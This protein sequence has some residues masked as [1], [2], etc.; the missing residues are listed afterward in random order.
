VDKLEAALWSPAVASAPALPRAGIKLVRFVYAVLRDAL[1]GDL[2]LRAM[3][4]VY[5]TILS[6]VPLIAISFSVLK[7]FGFHKQM[8]P[9][10]YELLAPLG[11]RGVQLTDQVMGF[12]DNIQGDVLAYGGLALLFFTTISMAQKVEA[13][14]NFV[15]RVERSRNIAQ[16][17]TQYL[18]IIML[19]PVVMVTA[20]SLIA[21]AEN[22]AVVRE[23]TDIQAIG[24]SV[25]LARNL[26]PYLLV[27]SGFTFV[28]LF[29][30]NTRVRLG[31][32]AVGGLTGGV[33]WATTGI[34]FAAF[35]A[36]SARTLNIYA[37]FAIVIIALIWLY[38]CWLI[39]LVGAQV[40]FYTQH[41]EHLRLGF[42][43]VSLGS[44]QRE[45]IALSIMSLAAQR[46]RDGQQHPRLR[47]VATE[48]GLPSLALSATVDRL[49][50]AGLLLHTDKDELL[51][52]QDP[53]QI[54]LRDVLAAVREPQSTDV[55]PE[56]QWPDGVKR[57]ASGI[58]Q[59]I[60]ASVAD[61]SIYD[62]LDS[63]T[64][65]KT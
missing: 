21:A 29:L 41:P 46:F 16:R 61:Q 24:E 30:P 22:N 18:S 49:E 12:V 40:A 9:L 28:Y 65:T 6:I 44:R 38:L 51:P 4:L 25:T 52:G 64:V 58:S 39:L 60:D 7:G 32:A 3:G 19:G 50:A 42:R 53:G 15:W 1:A 8:E 59:A 26:L 23:L 31:P 43:P 2:P 17:L 36:T 33:L 62:L 57:I 47:D 56:G 55:F 5:V 27:V 10:L 11:E 34:L 37:T 54:L 13:S 20:M 48:L 63:G 14:L 45:E 35:V